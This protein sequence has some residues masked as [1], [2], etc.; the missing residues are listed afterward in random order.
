MRVFPS[1]FALILAAALVAPALPAEAKILTHKKAGVKIDLPD[2]WSAKDEGDDGTLVVDA[3]NG[4]LA[5]TFSVVEAD[6]LE[7]VLEETL[8]ALEEEMGEIEA[9][10]AEDLKINGMEGFGID[11]VTKKDGIHVSLLCLLTP[12]NK[13]LTIF[14]FASEAAAKKYDREIGR[15]VRGIKKL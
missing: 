8:T 2:K 7:T 14:Y 3:P 4:E 11:G 15:I 12:K 5:V 9:D 13:C 10:D 1:L 6:Q